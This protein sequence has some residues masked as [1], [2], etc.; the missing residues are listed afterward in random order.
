M[1]KGIVVEAEIKKTMKSLEARN[2]KAWF[3][4]NRLEATNIML[5]L[6]PQD[7]IVGVGDSS[8]IRQ[9][10]IIKNLKDRGTKVINPYDIED[11]IKDEKT[12]LEFNFKRKVEAILCDVFLAGTNALTQDGRLLN[13]DATGN[14]VAGMLWGHPRVLLVV[15]RNKIV[16][17]LDEA[18]HRLKNVIV[19]QHTR[20]RSGIFSPPCVVRGKCHDCMGNNRAC[21]V[22][23]IIEGKPFQTEINVVIVD[24][25]LGLGWNEAWPQDR[26]DKIAAEHEKFMWT[27]P[28]ELVKTL[29]KK[30]LWE[31]VKSQLRSKTVV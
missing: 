30:A 27:F 28:S 14:R 17:D 19:P 9:I 15:G 21:N 18:F 3:A 4:N 29:D 23:V 7:A 11:V 13:I 24:Q 12:Y 1:R 31:A 16:K 5:D 25:D 26:I 2:L 8:T 6:I 20:R 10:G 22:T